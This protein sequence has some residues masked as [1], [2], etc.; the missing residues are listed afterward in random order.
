MA[1]ILNSA[2]PLVYLKIKMDAP[3]ATVMENKAKS[4]VIAVVTSS[5]LTVNKTRKGRM[6]EAAIGMCW[7]PKLLRYRQW[8][9]GA[10]LERDLEMV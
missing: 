10:L 1:G 6:S 3:T 5:S 7:T 9:D 4:A 2:R 8:P